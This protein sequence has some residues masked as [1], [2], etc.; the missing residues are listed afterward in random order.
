MEFIAISIVTINSIWHRLRSIVYVL[1]NCRCTFANLVAPPM[2]IARNRLVRC[3]A[4][5][6]N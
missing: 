2:D 3:N 6:D 4:L 1:E 5:N